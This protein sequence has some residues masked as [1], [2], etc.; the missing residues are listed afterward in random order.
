[1]TTHDTAMLK[2]LER[3]R[4]QR[5]ALKLA[6]Q[7]LDAIVKDT[8]LPGEIAST[9]GVTAA[10]IVRIQHKARLSKLQKEAAAR[11]RHEPRSRRFERSD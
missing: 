7:Q 4:A 2:E 8:R 1:M 6:L 10:I 5:L 11:R 9:Y 3:D